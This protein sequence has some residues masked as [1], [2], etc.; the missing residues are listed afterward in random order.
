MALQRIFGVQG[1]GHVS[2]FVGQMVELYPAVVTAVRSNGFYLQ[3]EDA[4]RYGNPSISEGVFVFTYTAPN[5]HVGDLVSVRGRASE[6]R[7]FDYDCGVTEIDCRATGSFVTIVS[8]GR[9]MPNAI[10]IGASGRMPP[11]SVIKSGAT[12]DGETSGGFSPSTNGLDF[13]ESVEGMRVT[14]PGAICVAPTKSD[15]FA[16]VPDGGAWATNRTARGGLIVRST[17]FNP[18]RILCDGNLIQAALP[19]VDV[20]DTFTADLQGVMGYANGNYRLHLTALPVPVKNGLA[21]ETASVASDAQL[22]IASFNVHGLSAHDPKATY[23]GLAATIVS[24]LLSPDLI[25]LEE[26]QDNSGTA[27]SG[28]VSASQTMANLI[29]AIVRAGGPTYAY[30]AIDPG[31]NTD[32][33]TFA[34]N[35]RT[36]FL[37]RT[38]R[39]LAFVDRLTAANQTVTA[40]SVLNGAHGLQLAFSPGRVAPMDAAWLEVR[41]PLAGEFLFRGTRF[42]VIA[43][44]FKSKVGDTPIFGRYQPPN[45]VTA[46]QRGAEAALV[47]AFVDSLLA[48]D[49]NAKIV[50]IGDLNDFEW[51]SAMTTLKGAV[52]HSLVDGLAANER[53]TYNQDGNAQA[54][55]HVLISDWL[56][57][58]GSP[59]FDI[60]HVNS[61]FADQLSDHDPLLLRLTI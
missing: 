43:C 55:D 31:N 49:A 19:L 52:L 32:G 47:N 30:R 9:S 53:Y 1:A 39:G 59:V 26:I 14:I 34:G 60:I 57:A 33:G 18:E 36:A 17:D 23:D 3:E 54:M 46:A 25:C 22:S 21:K 51:S 40:V 61:E 8:G 29:A 7:V 42:F 20:G 2:S 37:F 58:H 11:L 4:N 28:I 45:E 13:Y 35:I 50:V 48:V 15:V 44:H 24:H 41:K 56:N 38:G 6:T 16:V 10:V 5:A 27:D 12:G